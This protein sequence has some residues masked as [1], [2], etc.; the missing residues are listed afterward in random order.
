[1]LFTYCVK[2]LHQEQN[3]D[4]AETRKTEKGLQE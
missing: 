2:D 3:L 4:S 1:M